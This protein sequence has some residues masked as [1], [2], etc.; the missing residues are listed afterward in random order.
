MYLYK[1]MILL[2]FYLVPLSYRLSIFCSRLSCSAWKMTLSLYFVRGKISRRNLEKRRERK[3]KKKIA[4]ENKNVLK[5]RLDVENCGSWETSE[6]PEEFVSLGNN[7]SA[8]HSSTFLAFQFFFNIL[9]SGN[10]IFY[11][12]LCTKLNQIKFVCFFSLLP[13]L[14]YF[15]IIANTKKRAN[16]LINQHI[17]GSYVSVRFYH[18]CQTTFFHYFNSV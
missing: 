15:N 4:A 9:H 14:E 8:A 18:K 5:H 1:N 16:R 2:T 7:C 17:F 13:F 12:W 11:S 6:Y 10:Y 3:K